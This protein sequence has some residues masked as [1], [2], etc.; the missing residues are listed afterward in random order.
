MSTIGT[1]LDRLEGR[2]GG[3][4]CPEC[5]WGAGAPV[6]FVVERHPEGCRTRVR[7]RDPDCRGCRRPYEPERCGTCRRPLTFTIVLDDA[8]AGAD[9]LPPAD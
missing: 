8:A 2:L 9:E 3:P 1:R 5:G 4:G 7:D 6:Q